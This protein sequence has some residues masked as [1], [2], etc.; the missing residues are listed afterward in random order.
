M[1]DF[2]YLDSSITK[3]IK[4]KVSSIFVMNMSR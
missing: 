1:I 4:V 2:Y 3:E